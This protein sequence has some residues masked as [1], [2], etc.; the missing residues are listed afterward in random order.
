MGVVSPGSQVSLTSHWSNCWARSLWPLS[1]ASR[2]SGL[3]SHCLFSLI[4][5]LA[6]VPRQEHDNQENASYQIE[7]LLALGLLGKFLQHASAEGL[8]HLPA[9]HPT[10]GVRLRCLLV[11]QHSIHSG[12]E[13]TLHSYK[14][15]V[16][17][18]LPT[19]T[20]SFGT[21][22]VMSN[23]CLP[24]F[25]VSLCV[26]K[27]THTTPPWATLYLPDPQCLLDRSVYC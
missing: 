20:K 16:L 11:P 26:L 27:S 7:A 2:L 19:L 15:S 23:S 12:P 18:P 10:S 8:W 3:P 9:P 24:L 1:P 22:S 6:C 17:P 21:V 13:S 14:I 5:L 25:A 4:G